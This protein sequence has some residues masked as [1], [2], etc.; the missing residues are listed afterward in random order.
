MMRKIKTNLGSMHVCL[1]KIYMWYSLGIPASTNWPRNLCT[2]TSYKKKEGPEENAGHNQ[3]FQRSFFSL[4][5][6]TTNFLVKTEDGLWNNHGG[7]K[8]LPSSPQ[9]QF[10]EDCLWPAYENKTTPSSWIY[11]A[12]RILRYI[13]WAQ[14]NQGQKE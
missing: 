13:V 5:R 4:R 14:I 1:H 9:S 10:S 12:W 2:S 8:W 6:N 11:I 7:L 3:N